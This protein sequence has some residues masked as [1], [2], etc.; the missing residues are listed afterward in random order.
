MCSLKKKGL[1]KNLE[2]QR[3]DM[4]I[5][6]NAVLE[7]LKSGRT[8][9][10]VLMSSGD[11]K[12]TIVQ[13]M[14]KCREKGIV[15]KEV[16]SV[17]LDFMCAKGNHQG[18]IALCAVHEYASLDDIFEAAEKKGQPPFIII[19]DEIEDPHNLGAIIRT[20]E[21]VGAN[22]L[23]IPKRRSASL[24]FSV[25]KASAGA[26]EYLPVVKVSNL[27]QT[28]EELKQRGV[29]IFGAHMEGNPWCKADLKGSV[30]IVIGSEGNGI[31][32]L[33]KQKCDLLLSLPMSGKINSLNAS[34][35]GGILMYEVARQRVYYE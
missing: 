21:A 28:I 20:A 15:L 27:V 29:W 9:D 18:V 32:N 12:G 6:R 2:N 33:I 8:V 25:A 14:A 30:A 19:C 34:V 13:I 17:K 26:T 10:S 31:G 5:G 1:I 23:I 24:S 3:D 11:K 22:G 4:I 16:S 35:A 7:L